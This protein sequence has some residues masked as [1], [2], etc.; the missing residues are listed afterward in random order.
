MFRVLDD[1]FACWAKEAESTLKVLDAIPDAALEATVAEGHRN[2]KR[3][4]WHLVETLI[5]MPGRVGLDVEGSHL[6]E[7]G[8]MADPPESMILIRDAYARASASLLKGLEAWS[9]ADLEREDEMYGE[10]WKRGITLWVL[11]THQIHHRGQMTVLMRQAGLRVPD[12]Y[13]PAK[14]GWAAYGMEAPKV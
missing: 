4:A 13:G 9:D 1:F 14:E 7:V 5:E 2:L 8:L 12:I 10:T 6:L 11:V 3:M